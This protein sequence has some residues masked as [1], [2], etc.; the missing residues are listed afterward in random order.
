ML[1]CVG[2]GV[3][4]TLLNCDGRA[5]SN[6]NNHPHYHNIFLPLLLQDHMIRS[7]QDIFYYAVAAKKNNL[8]DVLHGPH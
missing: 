3:R 6:N 7:F 2:K 5:Y 8:N 1:E 4:I